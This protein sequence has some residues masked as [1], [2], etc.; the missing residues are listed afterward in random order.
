MNRAILWPAIAF[1]L[2]AAGYAQP[3]IAYRAIYNV[4]SYMAPGL[5]AGAIAQGSVFAIFGANIG[6]AATP[7]SASTFPLQT[8][9]GGVSITVTQGSTTVNAIPI[10]F[11]P[12]QIDAIMPSNAP[13]G[14]ASI[15]VTYNNS[16]SNSAPVQI[17]ASSF[18][19]ITANSQGNGPAIVQNYANGAYPTNSLQ[20]PAQP[21]Q[22]EVLW[23]TGLGAAPFADNTVP[24]AVNLPVQTEVFVGGISANVLYH[25]RSPCC[26]GIDEIQFT[27]PDQAPQGCWVPIYVRTNGTTVSNFGTIAITADGSACQEPNNPLAAALIQ[28]GTIGNYAAA[29]IGVHQ[30]VAVPSTVD[31]ISDVLG[32]FQAQEVAGAFN[33]NPMFS[34]PPAGTCTNY[35]VIGDLSSNPNALIPG[36]TPPTGRGLDAG[37]ISIQGQKGSK[38]ATASATNP[39]ISGAPLAGSVTPSPLTNTTFLDP[40]TFTISLSGGKDVGAGSANVTIP[41]PLSWTNRDQT[42]PVTRANGFTANWTGGDPTSSV[43][44]VGAGTDLPSN[45]TDVFLCLA[46]P[47]AN[48]FTVP[49]DVLANIPATRARLIQSKGAIYVGQWNLKGA[50]TIQATGFNF[51]SLVPVFASGTTVTFQ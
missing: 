44:I 14:A 43:F 27:V 40:G 12:G 19:V 20:L 5:P 2:V 38:S 15:Q 22:V 18:G 11:G 13:L 45:S 41:Q 51:S 25:G 6:P 31:T 21:G 4:G 37:T 24:T 1:G 28:G 48:S 50:G 46:P 42:S 23:G 36:M 29:R 16:K 49:K 7:P 26:S 34:L 3:Y 39:G 8:T 17:V 35:S 47:G 33:F 9:V 30:A 32:A 10:A